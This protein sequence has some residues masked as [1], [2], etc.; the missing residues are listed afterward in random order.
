MKPVDQKH[1]YTLNKQRGDCWRACLASILEVDIETF[2]NWEVK[3][4]WDDYYWRILKI[5]EKIGYEYSSL[6]IQNTELQE[7]ESPDTGNYII[8]IG[9]SPRAVQNDIIN[10]AV[11]W[12]NGIVHDPHPDKTGILNI[13]RFEVLSKK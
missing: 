1:L 3:Q 6:T 11:V 7:L 4:D 13:I 8:A 2:P 5:L 12:K 10:H 9:K